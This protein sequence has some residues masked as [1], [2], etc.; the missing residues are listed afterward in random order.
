[1]AV[2]LSGVVLLL[3]CHMQAAESADFCPLAKLGGHCDKARQA[4][5][6]EKL[7]QPSNEDGVDCCAFIPA[8]FDKTRTFE[9]R[10]LIAFSS[11]SSIEIEQA[12]AAVAVIPKTSCS[13]I[14]TVLPKNDT[15]LRNQSFR[16]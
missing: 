16:L 11:A 15:F 12:R 1:M 8:F 3:C 10:Q 2:W 5:D 6:A 13:H 7:T 14:S 4:R 9:G